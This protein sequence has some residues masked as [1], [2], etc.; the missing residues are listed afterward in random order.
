MQ[1]PRLGS[2]S[3]RRGRP[4]S[5]FK[6]SPLAK[7]EMIITIA[8]FRQLMRTRPV[9]KSPAMAPNTRK[10]IPRPIHSPGKFRR[11]I[12]GEVNHQFQQ[13]E[14][15]ANVMF[16]IRYLQPGPKSLANFS[17]DHSPDRSCECQD[18]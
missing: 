4:R 14:T 11:T 9:V 6:S 10:L 17:R 7:Q 8:E 18:F 16:E 15:R 13:A 2:P 3:A 5:N 12:V 1:S